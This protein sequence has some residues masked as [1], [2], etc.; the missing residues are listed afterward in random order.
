MQFHKNASQE[1]IW[2]LNAM[3][4]IYPDLNLDF[5]R[6]PHAQPPVDM[7]SDPEPEDDASVRTTWRT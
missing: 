4:Q 3:E 6:E 1:Q 5:D 2:I 7:R